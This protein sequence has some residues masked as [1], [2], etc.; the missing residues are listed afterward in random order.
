MSSETARLITKAEKL[1]QSTLIYLKQTTDPTY[2]NTLRRIDVD[3][4]IPELE[5][6]LFELIVS[7]E[8]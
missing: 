4:L 6:L 2:N 7:Q 5:Q 3:K 8:E 1:V